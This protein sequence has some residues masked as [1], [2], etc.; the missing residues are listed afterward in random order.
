M[1]KRENLTAL[2]ARGLASDEP[3]LATAWG[4]L[5]I[6]GRAFIR[7]GV[8]AATPHRLSFASSRWGRESLEEFDYA[9]ITAIAAATGTSGVSVNGTGGQSTSCSVSFTH[10]G[11]TRSV[12]QIT[13]IAEG[14]ALVKAAQRALTI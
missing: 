8:L 3:L 9:K 10:A 4:G 7:W 13:S 11:S 2:I 12:E 14:V 5:V 6:P 1:G